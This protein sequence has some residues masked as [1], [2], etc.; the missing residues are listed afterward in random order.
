M[1][2]V[3]VELLFG[4][5]CVSVPLLLLDLIPLPV[6]KT[7]FGDVVQRKKRQKEKKKGAVCLSFSA[8]SLFR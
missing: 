1:Y 3:L 6:A 8:P 5:V 7:A 4:P 2:L